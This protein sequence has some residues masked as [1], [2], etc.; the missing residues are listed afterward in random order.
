MRPKSYRMP[1]PS[2]LPTAGDRLSG[3]SGGLF[4]LLKTSRGEIAKQSGAATAP[5][6]LSTLS[7]AIVGKVSRLLGVGCWAVWSLN[8]GRFAT[9]Q[10]PKK[11]RFSAVGCWAFWALNGGRFAAI[12]N[13]KKARLFGIGSLPPAHS[14]GG[15]YRSSST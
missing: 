1:K 6:T 13:P 12:Q 4:N 7:K 3:C 15:V 5:V 11:A 2:R 10:I 14:K 9:V 8:G